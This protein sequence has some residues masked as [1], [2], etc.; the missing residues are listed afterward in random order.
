MTSK[1]WSEEVMLLGLV[2]WAIRFGSLFY[3]VRSL[4]APRSALWEEAQVIY[5]EATCRCS[6]EPQP[7][8]QLT[9]SIKT[10]SL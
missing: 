7:R 5:E 9:A 6:V 4:T 10:T 2:L 3:L 8:C 1:V